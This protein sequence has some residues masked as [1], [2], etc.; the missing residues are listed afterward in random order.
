V[1]RSN[2]LVLVLGPSRPDDASGDLGIT[3]QQAELIRSGRLD[4][5]L[6][7]LLRSPQD[8]ASADATTTGSPDDC[9]STRTASCRRASSSPS[10]HEPFLGTER[11]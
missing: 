3:P 5:T 7:L 9:W 4:G 2:R 10:R 8:A 1:K 11:D 6:T